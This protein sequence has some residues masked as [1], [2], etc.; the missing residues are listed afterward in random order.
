MMMVSGLK[1]AC[2]GFLGRYGTIAMLLRLQAG[3]RI[4]LSA[5][6]AWVT[7]PRWTGPLPMIIIVCA[8]LGHLASQFQAHCRKPQEA[9]GP[10]WAIWTPRPKKLLYGLPYGSGSC[11]RPNGHG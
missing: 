6:G 10:A 8:S 2:G 5:T 11:L 7:S 1:A 9:S 3:A 4:S